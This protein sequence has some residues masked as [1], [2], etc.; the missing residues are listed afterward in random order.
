MRSVRPYS[1][2]ITRSKYD[3]V[4]FCV[5][6]V[7]N[8]VTPKFVIMITKS[9]VTLNFLS[10]RSDLKIIFFLHLVLCSPR[11]NHTN[12]LLRHYLRTNIKPIT[13]RANIVIVQRFHGNL[14]LIA[15]TFTFFWLHFIWR[16]SNF[17]DELAIGTNLDNFFFFFGTANFNPYKYISQNKQVVCVFLDIYF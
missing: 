17:W 1:S 12:E 9:I 15:L 4:F 3:I 8:F 6:L 11:N 2:W 5:C 14:F 16:A 13:L 10:L 7:I